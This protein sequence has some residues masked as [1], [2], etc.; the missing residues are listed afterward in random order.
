MKTFSFPTRSIPLSDSWDVIV[1]GGGPA[2]CTAAAAAARE[3]AKTLLIEVSGALGGSGTSALVPSW[4]PFSDKER[5]IYR[6]LAERVLNECK[7]G[8]DH[9]KPN[10][11]DWV[12]IDPERL[13]RVYDRLV[14]S[15]GAQILFNTFLAAVEPDERGGV[16]TIV[17]GNKGGLSALQAKVF[18]DCTG[19]AD[20]S[21]W[22]GAEFN[23]GVKKATSCR[24]PTALSSP[25]WMNTPTRTSTITGANSI[26]LIP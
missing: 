13:K 17:I 7:E 23:Q 8:M 20:L 12:P 15:A 10:H 16:S 18:V 19:D 9:V 14:T 2:G 6:G 1:A 26:R 11:V 5:V 25:T 22:A 24:R 4:C 21:A 3:G